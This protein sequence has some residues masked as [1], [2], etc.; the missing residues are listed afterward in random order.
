MK[1]RRREPGSPFCT[2]CGNELEEFCFSPAAENLEALYAAALRCQ[3]EDRQNGKVCAKV[4][5]AG[6]GPSA[7]LL[8]KP[9]RRITR[10]SLQAL[11]ESI[12]RTIREQ[13]D[14]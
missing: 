11:K 12:L 8:A 1:R 7:S 13:A 5:I 4:F 6:E 2:R 3:L 9:R 10:K 14:R